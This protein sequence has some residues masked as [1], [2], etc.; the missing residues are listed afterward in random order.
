MTAPIT[1]TTVPKPVA[2]KPIVAE[3]NTHSTSTTIKGL[4]EFVSVA[5]SQGMMGQEIDQMIV[6]AVDHRT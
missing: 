3:V 1:V 2:P 4:Q 6:Q 5:L